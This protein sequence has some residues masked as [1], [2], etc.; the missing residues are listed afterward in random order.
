M[1]GSVF[2]W[3][4]SFRRE[5]LLQAALLP[6]ENR[7]PSVSLSNFIMGFPGA[8]VCQSTPLTIIFG[9]DNNYRTTILC[10]VRTCDHLAITEAI[11]RQHHTTVT[12]LVPK[13]AND[14]SL[15]IP[16]R[17][18]PC[19]K[20]LM[21]NSCGSWLCVSFSAVAFWAICSE[22]PSSTLDIALGSHTIVGR[23]SRRIPYIF[24]HFPNM[25]PQRLNGDSQLVYN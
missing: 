13:I 7:F 4:I 9:V 12:S 5:V 23:F 18:G 6:A 15:I 25:L 19:R 14:K 17:M 20:P 2:E 10:R 24:Q 16:T 21:R 1:S 8:L 22:G 3:A 11:A